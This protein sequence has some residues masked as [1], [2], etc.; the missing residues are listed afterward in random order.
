M[1]SNLP[2]SDALSCTRKGKG[3]V[4]SGSFERSREPMVGGKNKSWVWSWEAPN[5]PND[6]G[7]RAGA[8]SARLEVGGRPPD[9]VTAGSSWESCV[10]SI[11][12][13]GSWV[14]KTAWTE[15]ARSGYS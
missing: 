14:S 4:G 9:P 7:S 6:G 1:D 3:E 13:P 11:A 12:A 5:R 8:F 10:G 2:G 15:P